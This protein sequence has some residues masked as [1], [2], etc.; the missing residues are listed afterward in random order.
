MEKI[1]FRFSFLDWRKF[2]FSRSS[3]YI[4]TA[5]GD[6]ASQMANYQISDDRAFTVYNDIVNGSEPE[7]RFYAMVAAST[8]IAT[9]G[10]IQDSAAVVIGAMLVA[11]LMT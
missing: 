6:I 2:I 3:F 5:N 7:A 11:P 8:A 1:K 10:L 4:S 9:F